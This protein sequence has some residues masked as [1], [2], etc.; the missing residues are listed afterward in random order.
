MERSLSISAPM[1]GRGHVITPW[2]AL[3]NREWRSKPS[4]LNGA[5]TDNLRSGYTHYALWMH[6]PCVLDSVTMPGSVN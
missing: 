3:R 5:Q 6:S 4:N 2:N 1:I